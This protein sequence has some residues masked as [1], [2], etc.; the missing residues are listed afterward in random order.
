MTDQRDEHD[1]V[2][3]RLGRDLVERLDDG[4][5]RGLARDALVVHCARFTVRLRLVHQVDEP[6]G[7]DAQLPG[8]VRQLRAPLLEHLCVRRISSET[9]DDQEEHLHH[10]QRLVPCG[11]YASPT[12]RR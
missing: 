4:R 1:I 3:A 5:L 10:K 6:I 12:A 9:D 2:R 8:R 11:P 7:G